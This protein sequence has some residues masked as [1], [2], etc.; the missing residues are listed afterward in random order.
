MS[1]TTTRD[2]DRL[3]LFTDAVVAIA[4][5]LLVLPL[6]ELVNEHVEHPAEIVTHNWDRLGSFALS[7]VVIARFWMAHHRVFAHVSQYTAR[8][9]RWNMLWLFTTVLLPF[10]TGMVSRFGPD[11]FTMAFYIG[12]VGVSSVCLTM[13][14]LLIHRNPDIQD[15]ENPLHRKDVISTVSTTGLIVV[16]LIVAMLLPRVNYYALLLLLLTPVVTRLWAK[17]RL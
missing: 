10:P 3:V 6:V 1:T 9:M 2:P 16:A 17:V 4:I 12:T 8:L 13:L 5:T 14:T 11:H 7:F 15:A